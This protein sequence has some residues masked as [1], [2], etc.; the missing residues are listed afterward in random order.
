MR[1]LVALLQLNLGL[2]K[3]DLIKTE[4]DLEGLLASDVHGLLVGDISSQHG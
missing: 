3:E 2:A 4:N 1:Q